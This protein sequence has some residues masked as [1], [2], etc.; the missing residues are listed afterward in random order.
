[1][2][3]YVDVRDG[4]TEKHWHKDNA[5]DHA[6]EQIQLA[7]PPAAILNSSTISWRRR[8]A[9]SH[10]HHPFMTTKLYPLPVF[11]GITA[12]VGPWRNFAT[13]EIPASS[14]SGMYSWSHF[15]LSVCR[16]SG[17]E[18]VAAYCSGSAYLDYECISVYWTAYVCIYSSSFLQIRLVLHLFS[19][20]FQPLHIPLSHISH[21]L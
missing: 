21:M 17:G 19:R 8:K 1:M 4:K 15:L 14:C 20:L 6:G 7:S 5:G 9:K 2:F 16:R 12:A 18:R 11:E 3:G 10:S 13:V